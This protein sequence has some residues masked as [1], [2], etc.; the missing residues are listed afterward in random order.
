MYVCPPFIYDEKSKWNAH[1]MSCVAPSSHRENDLLFLDLVL[2]WLYICTRCSTTPR[3][4]FPSHQLCRYCR[5]LEEIVGCSHTHNSGGGIH[6]RLSTLFPPIGRS[7]YQRPSPSW[8]HH[9]RH[10]AIN[11]C[12]YILLSCHLCNMFSTVCFVCTVSSSSSRIA[13]LCHI[14]VPY[15]H[16]TTAVY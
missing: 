15:V 5:D 10:P 9:S 3:M 11:I 12:Y 13:L 2:P 14:C 6:A 8:L 16:V 7:I 1:R 4:S